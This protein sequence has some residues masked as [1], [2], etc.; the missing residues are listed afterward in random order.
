V[1]IYLGAGQKH[2]RSFVWTFLKSVLG[3]LKNALPR[4]TSLTFHCHDK[5]ALLNLFMVI[6]DSA[7]LVPGVNFSSVIRRF[8]ELGVVPGRSSP[9]PW[10]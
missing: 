10:H 3:G 4:G 5:A 2:N 7:R 8:M 1:E 6:N 9:C